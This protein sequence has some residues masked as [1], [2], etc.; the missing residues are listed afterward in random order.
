MPLVVVDTDVV[1]FRFKKDSRARLYKR[2][3][4]GQDPLIAFMT[5]AELNAWSLERRWG[6][7]RLSP[8]RGRGAVIQSRFGLRN[9]ACVQ[10]IT[11]PVS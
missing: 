5:L 6:A 2:H 11:V 8:R 7:A 10:S 3:L 4:I 1:S 9:G